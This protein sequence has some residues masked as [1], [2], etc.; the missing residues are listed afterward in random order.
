[1]DVVLASSQ[2]TEKQICL[3]NYCRLFSQV[4][5]LSNICQADGK[6][7]D[8][9]FCVDGSAHSLTSTL[10]PS[11]HHVEQVKPDCSAWT[12]WWLI[13]RLWAR[14]DRCL[15]EPMRRWFCPA[16]K[17]RRNWKTY[18]DTSL[19]TILFS[20]FGRYEVHLGHHHQFFWS[21][22]SYYIECLFDG[23]VPATIMDK[24]NTRH[25]LEYQHIY[26]SSPPIVIST[27]HTFLI[28]PTMG[29][30]YSRACRLSF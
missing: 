16:N 9:A 19:K 29:I 21:E 7:L 12:Q 6:S 30:G 8:P 3:V 26:P 13:C 11:H 27:F 25:L 18:Y 20:K 4:T 15:L 17:L 23:C 5:L 2:F 10:V 1:M 24:D 28:P 14:P 22:P